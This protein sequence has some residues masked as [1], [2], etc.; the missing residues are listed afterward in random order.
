M[1][2]MTPVIIIIIIIITTN[3]L[4]TT[5]L[6]TYFPPTPYHSCR[7]LFILIQKKEEAAPFS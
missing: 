1:N 5:D 6:P 4:L 7:A 3:G 2:I